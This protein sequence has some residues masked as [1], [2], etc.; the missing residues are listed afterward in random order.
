M[1]WMMVIR[2]VNGTRC[3]S[4]TVTSRHGKRKQVGIRELLQSNNAMSTLSSSRAAVRVALAQPVDELVRHDTAARVKWS[5]AV[6]RARFAPLRRCRRGGGERCPGKLR[7]HLAQRLVLAA[8]L[9][10][11][12]LENVVVDVESGT[13]EQKLMH[14]AFNC[15]QRRAEPAP[16]SRPAISRGPRT[17]R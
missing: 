17:S 1:A 11:R 4:R 9:F 13:H 2:A 12:S 6:M 8:R 10:L 16:T 3:H 5:N 15:Q 14:H 7:D